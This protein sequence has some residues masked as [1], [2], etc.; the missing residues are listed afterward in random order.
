MKYEQQEIMKVIN[1]PKNKQYE[2][3][4]KNNKLEVAI[5]M[6]EYCNRENIDFSIIIDNK[7]A[8][9]LFD[10]TEEQQIKDYLIITT[11]FKKNKQLKIDKSNASLYELRGDELG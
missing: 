10:E 7:T 11:S 2:N 1:F 9:D 8:L 4:L 6:L 3:K 5:S